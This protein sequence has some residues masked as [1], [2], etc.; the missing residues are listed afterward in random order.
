MG[1]QSFAVNFITH[2]SL[3]ITPFI[4][5]GQKG[6]ISFRYLSSCIIAH[7]YFLRENGSQLGKQGLGIFPICGE[8]KRSGQPAFLEEEM[9]V[10]FLQIFSSI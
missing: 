8:V 2:L 10:R 7:R 5:S 3:T 6:I 1:L 4:L 9:Q